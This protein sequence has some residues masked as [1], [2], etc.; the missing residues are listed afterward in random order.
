[1]VAMG[2]WEYVIWG[3]CQPAR[4]PPEPRGTM[5][6]LRFNKASPVFRERLW[7]HGRGK[8]AAPPIGSIVIQRQIDKG[9]LHVGWQRCFKLQGLSR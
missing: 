4:W 3:A 8:K 9:R 7:E 6:E 1:M 2:H 5:G